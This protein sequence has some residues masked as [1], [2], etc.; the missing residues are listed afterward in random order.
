[1]NR[2]LITLLIL[3]FSASA[4]MAFEPGDTV[5]AFALQDLEG[6]TV[7]LAELDGL[8]V[9]DFWA[10]WCPPCKVEVPYLQ[11]FY[12]D[13][14]ERGLHV[15]GVSTESVEVQEKFRKEMQEDGVAMDYIL[16]VDPDRSVTTQYKI[17]GIPTTIFVKPDKTVIHHEVGFAPQYAEKFKEIIEDNLPE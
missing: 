4:V 6:N 17:Q 15:I 10:T 5:S 16:L 7:D 13:Y 8:L 14:K 3:V 1:M 11:K 9:L 12:D 2:I